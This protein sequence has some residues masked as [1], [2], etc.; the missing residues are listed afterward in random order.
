[1]ISGNERKILAEAEREC[2]RK[3]AKIYGRFKKNCKFLGTTGICFAFY[4]GRHLDI[5]LGTF[6][7]IGMLPLLG[8]MIVE[9]C[10]V[11]RVLRKYLRICEA[12]L[13]PDDDPDPD[14]EEETPDEPEKNSEPEPAPVELPLKKAA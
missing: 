4:Y 5:G 9:L 11:E 3:L 6:L 10:M 13:G 7:T 14:D 2:D 12:I 8:G 1:M